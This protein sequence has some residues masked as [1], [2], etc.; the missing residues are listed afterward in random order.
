MY[1]YNNPVI[2]G[3]M[4][5]L[6]HLGVKKGVAESFPESRLSDSIMQVAQD[7][8]SSVQYLIFQILLRKGTRSLSDWAKNKVY[9]KKYHQGV[10]CPNFSF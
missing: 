5:I 4:G 1:S 10:S 3:T 8:S 9:L 6:F 7:H 2:C